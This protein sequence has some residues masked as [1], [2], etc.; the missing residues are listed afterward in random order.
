MFLFIFFINPPSSY[1]LFSLFILLQ[2]SYKAQEDQVSALQLLSTGAR[3]TFVYT[4]LNSEA[5]G[6]RFVANTEDEMDA[7]EGRFMRSTY[8]DVIDDCVSFLFLYQISR[9]LDKTR[10]AN[11]L[12]SR[13][14]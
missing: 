5:Y 2:F 14:F 3:Q 1:W 11:M 9:F 10:T 7:A 6:T 12:I 13:A 4:C 8:I